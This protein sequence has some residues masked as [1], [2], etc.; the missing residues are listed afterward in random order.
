MLILANLA[1]FIVS[2]NR[3]E[4]AEKMFI[5]STNSLEASLGRNHPYTIYCISQYGGLLR[6]IGRHHD[7]LP[8]FESAY[9]GC[10]QLR[11]SQH[12]GTLYR[13][14]LLKDLLED[15]KNGKKGVGRSSGDARV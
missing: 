11:G 5:R 14:E 3:K 7:A 6:M 2:Q 1:N 4:E 13:E 8:L 10:Y 15:M 9:R 12:S